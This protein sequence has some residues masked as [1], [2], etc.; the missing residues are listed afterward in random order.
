MQGEFA[1][2]CVTPLLVKQP[3][4]EAVR[5]VM[6]LTEAARRK[7]VVNFMLGGLR[8]WRWDGEIRSLFSREARRRGLGVVCINRW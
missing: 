2:D 1:L 5:A 8:L 6:T 3:S 4:K 7:A